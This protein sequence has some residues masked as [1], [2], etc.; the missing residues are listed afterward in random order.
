M[1]VSRS[2]GPRHCTCTCGCVERIGHRST[3]DVRSPLHGTPR[4]TFK[5][6]HTHGQ[7]NALGQVTRPARAIVQMP[8]EDVPPTSN[9]NTIMPETRC[10][11]R[12]VTQRI[13]TSAHLNIYRVFRGQKLH[14]W[15]RGWSQHGRSLHHLYGRSPF[16]L[17]HRAAL[18][19][20]TR[21]HTH[22]HSVTHAP[23]HPR[24]SHA[25]QKGSS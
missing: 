17:H 21:T 10:D 25:L 9:T 8:Q 3:W 12:E 6:R 13:G 15:G 19:R 20:T 22:T 7:R 18:P 5:H 1:I 24:Q 4:Q 16:Y 23:T 14:W 2:S 11:A